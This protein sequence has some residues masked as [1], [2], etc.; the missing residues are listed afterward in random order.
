MTTVASQFQRDAN[1]V[2][3]VN[4]GLTEPKSITYSTL[5][6]GATGVAT[7]FTVTGTIAVRIFAVCSVD[8]TGAGA[9]LEVGILGN[10]AALIAQT[11][12]TTIDAGEIWA[13]TSPATVL[14]LPSLFIVSGTDIIQTIATHTVD[15]GVL[16]YYC[17]WTPISTDGNVVAA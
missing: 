1:H 16:T 2:P 9:T 17:V 8:L 6:T 14:A 11:T 15:A 12:G 10:T 3:I 13:T 7:L 5:T 4:L